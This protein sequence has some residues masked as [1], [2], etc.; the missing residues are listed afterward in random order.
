MRNR[1]KVK[2]T[3]TDELLSRIMATATDQESITSLL[4]LKN[5]MA[6]ANAWNNVR[7]LP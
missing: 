1:K 6:V 2:K 7:N 5:A 4:T 3:R